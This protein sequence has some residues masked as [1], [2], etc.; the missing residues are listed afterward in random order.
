MTNNI[1]LRFV[2]T[3]T[4]TAFFC[5][6]AVAVMNGFNS[7][8]K[9]GIMATGCGVYILMAM[10]FFSP[11]CCRCRCG[12]NEPLQSHAI[13]IMKH[14]SDYNTSLN[15]KLPEMAKFTSKDF[16]AA[17]ESYLRR[18]QPD[19][20]TLNSYPPELTWHLLVRGS[21]T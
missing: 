11:F 15:T 14:I 20:L 6:V 2:N 10:E 19:D 8:G 17:N 12:V 5:V 4:T 9:M 18:A 3:V 16:T 7:N 13:L 1:A 21:L